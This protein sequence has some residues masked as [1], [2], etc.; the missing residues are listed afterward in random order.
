[1]NW[2]KFFKFVD[3]VYGSAVSEEDSS[4]FVNCPECGE[5]FFKED[6]EGEPI[7]LACGFNFE[8]GE[9]EEE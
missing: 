6:Y 2:D 7:C 8:T 3:E 5:P 1:M 9:M 4:P